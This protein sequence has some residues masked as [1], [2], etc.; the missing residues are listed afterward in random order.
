MQGSPGAAAVNTSASPALN[1]SWLS[2]CPQLCEAERRGSSRI[3]RARGPIQSTCCG[4]RHKT[5]PR[6]LTIL[7]FPPGK[8]STLNWTISLLICNQP[9]GPA[10]PHHANPEPA[11][12]L[13]GKPFTMLNISTF[14]LTFLIQQLVHLFSVNMSYFPR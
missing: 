13:A 8:S 12:H 11:R 10:H 7:T 1:R 3:S 5:F 14:F 6:F 4:R 9:E 2:A